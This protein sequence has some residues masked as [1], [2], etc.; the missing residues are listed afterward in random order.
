[1]LVSQLQPPSVAN[2]LIPCTTMN[3]MCILAC[4]YG[5]QKLCPIRY[6]RGFSMC[7]GL[8]P[9]SWKGVVVAEMRMNSIDA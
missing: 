3:S 8:S 7:L 9:H 6:F 4:W 1:M 5:G 2:A